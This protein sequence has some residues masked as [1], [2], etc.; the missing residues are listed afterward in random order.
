VG[1]AIKYPVPDLVK[2]SFVFLTSGHSDACQ[3]IKN[4]NDDLTR[5]GTGHYSCTH[6]ATEGIKLQRVDCR[7]R[8]SKTEDIM[9]GNW[10][11]V[12]TEPAHFQSKFV[13]EL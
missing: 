12:M 4:T 5:S 3:D 9:Y 10:S 7:F 8:Q 2:S 1:A 6:V 11:H 13:S